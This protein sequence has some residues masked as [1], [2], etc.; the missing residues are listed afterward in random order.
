[1]ACTRARDELHNLVSFSPPK[2]NG[3]AS[4]YFRLFPELQSGAKGRGRGV[5]QGF[6]ATVP[7]PAH[8]GPYVRWRPEATWTR[9]RYAEAVLGEYLHRVLQDIDY[10]PQDLGAKI[11]ASLD[12][13]RHMAPAAD[14]KFAAKRLED[15]L[16]NPK[17]ACWFSA[18]RGRRVEREAEFIDRNGKLLRMDRVVHD[19]GGITVLDFKTGMGSDESLDGHLMQMKEYL[20]ALSQ[21]FP[22]KT[23]AGLVCYLDGTVA[24]VRP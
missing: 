23:L 19:D 15:F 4:P 12:R 10:L 13:H 18:A 21:A 1:V 24:E 8:A 3:E 17:I 7:E 22:E 5:G 9:S 16:G 6:E 14:R 20:A 2:K 11:E